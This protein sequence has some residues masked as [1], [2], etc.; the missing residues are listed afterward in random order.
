MLPLPSGAGFPRWANAFHI[1]SGPRQPALEV[2]LLL[3]DMIFPFRMAMSE[4][5]NSRVHCVG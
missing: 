3:H 5:C 1:G 2:V 4:E